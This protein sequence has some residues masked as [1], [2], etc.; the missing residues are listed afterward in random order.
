M[1]DCVFRVCRLETEEPESKASMITAQDPEFGPMQFDG[2]YWKLE[3]TLLFNGVAIPLQIEPENPD[4]VET[5]SFSPRQREA[6]RTALLLPS[7]VLEQA[8]PAV[9]QNYEVYREMVGDE[10]LPPLAS[11]VEVWKTVEPS[12]ISIPPHEG[13]RSYDGDGDNSIVT[14]LLFAECGWDPEHGLVVRFRNGQADAADQQ[15]EL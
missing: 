11:P 14:F 13:E 6:V 1:E 5:P 12:Y 8:A 9:V 7:N 3:R 15:G 2:Y 10:E 4:K